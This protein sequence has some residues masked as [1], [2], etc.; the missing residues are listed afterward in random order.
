MASDFPMAGFAVDD[1]KQ[2]HQNSKGKV[3][4]TAKMPHH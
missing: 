1:K 2:Y 4:E 3:M